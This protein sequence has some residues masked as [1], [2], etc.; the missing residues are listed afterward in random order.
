MQLPHLHWFTSEKF[1]LLVTVKFLS[2]YLIAL[3]S[4]FQKPVQ[5]SELVGAACTRPDEVS[6]QQLQ[7]N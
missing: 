3:H 2:D 5:L 1:I 6:F 7:E 4:S